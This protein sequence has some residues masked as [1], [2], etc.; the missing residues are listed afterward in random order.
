M[1]TYTHLF[2]P[3]YIC[4]YSH[5]FL[6]ACVSMSCVPEYIIHIYMNVYIHILYMWIPCVYTHFLFVPIHVC[7]YPMYAWIC[8]SHT[9]Y[10]NMYAHEHMSFLEES[11]LMNVNNTSQKIRNIS[12]LVHALLCVPE[13]TLCFHMCAHICIYGAVADHLKEFSWKLKACSSVNTSQK[14]RNSS[15]QAYPCITRLS[16]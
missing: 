2:F 10:S 16:T 9:L 6:L 13:Y 14:I 4:T 7:L 11:K 3:I 1:L 8:S 12:N 15:N 5:V